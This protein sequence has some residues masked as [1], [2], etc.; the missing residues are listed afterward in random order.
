MEIITSALEYGIP[1]KTLRKLVMS[2]QE[3]LIMKE[4]AA[5]MMAG[6]NSEAVEYLCQESFQV[7]QVREI[8]QAFLAGLN[9]EQVKTFASPDISASQMH[10]MWEQLAQKK[11]E[12]QGL[13]EYMKQILEIMGTAVLIS[14]L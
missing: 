8:V 4:I 14:T 1:I 9:L 2:G 5:G 3:A 12:D 11:E 6:L 7:Y 10:K 13:A